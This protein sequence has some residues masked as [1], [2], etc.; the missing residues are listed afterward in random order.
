MQAR[1]ELFRLNESKQKK[2]EYTLEWKRNM[3]REAMQTLEAVESKIKSGFDKGME[4]RDKTRQ[5]ISQIGERENEMR[6]KHKEDVERQEMEK[7]RNMVESLAKKD[8]AVKEFERRK[9]MKQK[10]AR[11][12]NVEKS[13]I[14][15]QQLAD[16]QRRAE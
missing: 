6:M 13:N 12:R 7:V 4:A 15:V 3:N 2:L 11:N 1:D 9:I 10:E 14:T 5:K 8:K 16:E